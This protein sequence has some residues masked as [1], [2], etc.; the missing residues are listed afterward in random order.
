LIV[1]TYLLYRLLSWFWATA[2]RCLFPAKEFEEMNPWGRRLAGL[3][4]NAASCLYDLYHP[5]GRRRQA[6]ARRQAQQAADHNAGDV[7]MDPLV[8]PEDQQASPSY[9]S[10]E[11]NGLYPALRRLVT[12]RG[13]RRR[14]TVTQDHRDGDPPEGGNVASDDAVALAPAAENT[15]PNVQ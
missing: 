13:P 9:V 14:A 6:M 10:F 8:P 4:P 15:S 2:Y 11:D 3:M 5:G 12:F 7:A 1:G